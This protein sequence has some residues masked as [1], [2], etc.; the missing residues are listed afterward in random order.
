MQSMLHQLPLTVELFATTCAIIFLGS[1]KFSLVSGIVWQF[2]VLSMDFH[3]ANQIGICAKFMATNCASIIFD[4]VVDNFHMLTKI[5]YYASLVITLLTLL[6]S[7]FLMN[8]LN[9]LTQIYSLCCCIITKGALVIFSFL[10][11]IISVPG[12]STFPFRL[13]ITVSTREASVLRHGDAT[14][15]LSLHQMGYSWSQF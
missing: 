7:D 9:M 3:V 10:M 12:H 14:T 2:F 6:V 11:D 8:L 1:L 15:L 5:A 4:I 13:V